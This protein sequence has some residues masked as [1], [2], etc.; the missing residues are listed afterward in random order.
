MELKD[1]QLELQGF[2]SDDD[3]DY[4]PKGITDKDFQEN[5]DF[6]QNHPLFMKQLPKDFE[7]NQDIAALQNLIYNDE[8]VKIAKKLNVNWVYFQN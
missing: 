8:P 1:P 2:D 6:F 7:K 4:V 5:I 3:W